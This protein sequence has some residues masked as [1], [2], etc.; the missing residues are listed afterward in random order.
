[1]LLALKK[2]L[3][4]WIFRLRHLRQVDF[5]GTAINLAH[6][7][8]TRG[9]FR[10][11]KGVMI[12]EPGARLSI[13][14][15]VYIGHFCNIRC[16]ESISIG[17]DVKFAQFVSVVDHD[18]DFTKSLDFAEMKTSAIEIGDG[19]WLGANSVVLRGVKLGARTIVAAGAVVT[20]SFPGRCV[21]AGSPA[22]V[23]KTF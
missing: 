7:P 9:P 8:T 3:N 13:G 2:R 4:S 1:M 20:K 6:L 5:F 14:S 10:F 16:M 11:H 17:N 22:R 12:V 15:N 18:Y 23:I 19:S 21:V